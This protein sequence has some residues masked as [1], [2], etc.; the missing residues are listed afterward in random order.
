MGQIL[1]IEVS[2][3]GSL[4]AALDS[5]GTIVVGCMKWEANNSTPKGQQLTFQAITHHDFRQYPPSRFYVQPAPQPNAGV[6]SPAAGAILLSGGAE[7][8]ELAYLVHYN[9]APAARGKIEPDPTWQSGHPDR[10][11]QAVVAICDLWTLTP[12]GG[13][14]DQIVGTIDQAGE[15]KIWRIAP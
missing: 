3:D 4:L 2:S 10:Q 11:K 6:A 7:D 8:G 15:V 1:R 12:P 13:G 14:E 5:N 9:G